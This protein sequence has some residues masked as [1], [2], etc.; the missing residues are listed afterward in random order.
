[1]RALLQLACGML[2]DAP[3]G[4]AQGY[5]A[6]AAILP[7]CSGRVVLPKPRQYWP[8]DEPID[9]LIWMVNN[10]DTIRD[11][12]HNGER[13]GFCMARGDTAQQAWHRAHSAADAVAE[14]VEVTP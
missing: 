5:A 14:S 10:G 3:L 4:P 12:R 2:V 8:R 6:C 7:K 1:M 9:R 13:I 11:P